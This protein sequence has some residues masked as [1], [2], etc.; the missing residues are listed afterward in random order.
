MIG[1]VLDAFIIDSYESLSSYE[2]KRRYYHSLR[3]GDNNPYIVHKKT[4][5]LTYIIKGFGKV[6][7]DGREQTI[8]KGTN[9][10]SV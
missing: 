9:L 6:S 7:L 3:P 10:G 4:N 2:K 8:S 1:D 5:Q